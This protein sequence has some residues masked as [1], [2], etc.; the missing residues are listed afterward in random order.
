MLLFIL[1]FHKKKLFIHKFVNTKC[2]VSNQKSV[3]PTASSLRGPSL[4]VCVS[5]LCIIKRSTVIAH[6]S[7]QGFHWFPLS[8]KS[9]PLHVFLIQYAPSVQ[10]CGETVWIFHSHMNAWWGGWGRCWENV[11]EQAGWVVFTAGVGEVLTSW[12]S[13]REEEEE[14]G[15]RVRW[16]LLAPV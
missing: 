6:W 2:K 4:C 9:Q 1:N 10:A 11:A 3:S 14:I 16:A 7:Q 13:A 8:S 5:G 15:Q 12:G